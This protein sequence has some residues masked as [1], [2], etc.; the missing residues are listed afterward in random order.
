MLSSSESR[1]PKSE[2]FSSHSSYV[3]SQKDQD[4][5]F[6][7]RSPFSC[8]AIC[9]VKRD[10]HP[11]RTASRCAPAKLKPRTSHL[12]FVGTQHQSIADI[13]LS[14][15]NSVSLQII[16]VTSLART[17]GFVQ[18]IPHHEP[19]A[20]SRLRP[21]H[22]RPHIPRAVALRYFCNHKRTTRREQPLIIS[23][24]IEPHPTSTK[25]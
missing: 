15:V 2:R 21:N 3:F 5:Y 4:E 13:S 25:T 16:L 24:Q 14:L 10:V 19:C 12:R 23:N 18:I 9:C 8:F 22:S 6:T 20:T 7:I 1:S 17:F 11:C